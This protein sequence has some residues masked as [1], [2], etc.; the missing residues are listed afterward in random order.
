MPEHPAESRPQGLPSG[1]PSPAPRPRSYVLATLLLSAFTVPLLVLTT[2][3]GWAWVVLLMVALSTVSGLL[4]SRAG[5]S[6][7]QL[8][9]VLFVAG[10]A[11][12]AFSALTGVLNGLSDEP[13]T[14][15]AYASLGLGLYTH[16]I[17]ISYVQFGVV[18][19]ETSYDVYLPLLAFAQVPGLDYRWVSLTAW[20]AMVV[21]LRGDP[22][23]TVSLSMAWVP[24]LAAN[25]QNDFVPLLALTIA[26]AGAPKGRGRWVEVVALGLKQLANVVVFAYHLVRREYL[27]ALASVAVTVA[28]LA[29]FVWIDPGAVYCHVLL[30]DPSSSCSP[31]GP[32]FFAFKRNYWLYPTW[33]LA[34]FYRPLSAWVR[35]AAQRFTH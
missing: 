22:R 3:P 12:A 7:T 19:T 35:R 27:L 1:G 10:L 24:L 14:T 5:A 20:A 9:R 26:L 6:E 28:I 32:G 16:P 2:V 13:Y 11:L 34:V 30:A 21:W 18:H 33:V 4:A 15:P 8:T 23:A 31:R 25:G 17:A 29:P